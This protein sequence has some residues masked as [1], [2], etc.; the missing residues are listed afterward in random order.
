MC[1]IN[2]I[3]KICVIVQESSKFHMRW[4]IQLSILIIAM[5]TI[6]PGELNSDIK[7]MGP[8]QV[9]IQKDGGWGPAG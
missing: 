6:K 3:F 8:I 4:K 1:I 9:L 5:H 7:I 2:F